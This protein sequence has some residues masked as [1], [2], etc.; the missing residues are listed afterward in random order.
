MEV[1]ITVGH[2]AY[3]KGTATLNRV[4]EAF[5]EDVLGEDGQINRKVLG[6]KVF[7]KKVS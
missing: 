7:G 6:G 2:R 4:V 3:A 1:E 5:G